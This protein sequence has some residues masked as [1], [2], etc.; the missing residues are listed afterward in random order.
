[1]DELGD[2]ISPEL[3]RLHFPYATAQHLPEKLTRR[4]MQ[5]LE[6]VRCGYSNREMA[7]NLEVCEDTI[8][9]H[10]KNILGKLGAK[11]RTHAVMLAQ[12]AGLL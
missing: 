3:F 11:A 8:K 2:N 5:I 6:H 10:M 12:H 1:M 9:Y 4:E 7:R